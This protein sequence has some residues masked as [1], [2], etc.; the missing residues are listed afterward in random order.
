MKSLIETL[1]NAATAIACLVVVGV[2]APQF[3]TQLVGGAAQPVGDPQNIQAVANIS[4]LLPKANVRGSSQGNVAFVEFSDFQCPFCG[5]FARDISGTFQKE[6]VDSGRVR[7][8][9]RN[10]P[11]TQMHPFALSAGKALLCAGDQQLFWPM[12]DRLFADQSALERS[13]L[14]STAAALKLE[15]RAFDQCLDSE[16]ADNRV[17]EDLAEGQRAGVTSTPMFFVGVVQPDGS[18][19]V[20]TRIRGLQPIDVLRKAVDAVLRASTVTR[21]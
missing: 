5:K 1:A 8:I 19:K 13:N 11:L 2:Y 7:Y 3:K 12:H 16:G 15:T 9:F 20:H 14:L 17:R 6:Y 18:I 21:T 10:F 4:L